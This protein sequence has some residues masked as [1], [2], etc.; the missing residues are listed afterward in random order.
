MH[1]LVPW[2]TL[3]PLPRK[4]HRTPG[5]FEKHCLQTNPS[6]SFRGTLQRSVHSLLWINTKNTFEEFVLVS[7]PSQTW[8]QSTVS[9]WKP[10]SL[11]QAQYLSTCPSEALLQQSLHCT[12]ITFTSRQLLR[13]VL[14]KSLL[15]QRNENI[16]YL[17]LSVLVT[18]K[19]FQRDSKKG[20]YPNWLFKILRRSLFGIHFTHLQDKGIYSDTDVQLMGD[21]A[22][23]SYSLQENAVIKHMHRKERVTACAIEFLWMKQ[24][25]ELTQ[26]SAVHIC[27]LPHCQCND[28]DLSYKGPICW[29]VAHKYC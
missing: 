28:R 27:T 22:W 6:P 2:E 23:V 9:I 12:E 13:E 11:L 14:Q 26:Y 15:W 17:S 10:Q 3:L 4:S 5:V 8:F 19:S 20:N 25:H 24:R 18:W 16:S 1:L 7:T 29:T 21:L